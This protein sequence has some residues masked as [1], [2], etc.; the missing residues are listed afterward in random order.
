MKREKLMFGVLFGLV[1]LVG[2]GSVSAAICEATGSGVC[3]YVSPIGN[4]ANNGTSYISPFQTFQIAINLAQPGDVIYGLGGTYGSASSSTWTDSWGSNNGFMGIT[5]K[6]LS[7]SSGTSINPITIKAYPGETP[8]LDGTLVPSA[9]NAIYVDKVS[10]W[11]I[12]GFEFIYSGIYIE[13]HPSLIHNIT[14]KNNYMHHIDAGAVLSNTGMIVLYRAYFTDGGTTDI[15][16]INNTFHDLERA[17]VGWAS[18]P[19]AS[20]TG[21]LTTLS[22]CGYSGQIT[23]CY[24]TGNI[25]FINNTVYNIAK[26][27]FFKNPAAG[28]VIIKGNIFHDAESFGLLSVSSIIMTDNLVYNVGMGWNTV[29]STGGSGE[30][31]VRGQ[32]QVIM[33]NTFV[34]PDRIMSM[35]VGENHTLKNNIFFRIAQG[36]AYLSR[37]LGNPVY[38]ED[39]DPAF[40]TLQSTTSEDNCFFVPNA[41]TPFIYREYD[42]PGSE[43]YTHAEQLPVFGFDQNSIFTYETNPNNV[44]VNPASG[45]YRLKNSSLCLGMG[46]YATSAP[47][48]P[49][50]THGPGISLSYPGDVGIAGDSRVIFTENFEEA[51]LANLFSN[52]DEVL[53]GGV[54]TNFDADVSS[55]SSGSQSIRIDEAGVG[56]DRL[57]K[58]LANINPS[59]Y[60]KLYVRYYI[61]IPSGS[62]GIHHTAMLGGYNPPLN[63][64]DGRSGAIPAGNDWFGTFNGPWLSGGSP[65]WSW[66]WYTYWMG[67]NGIWGN[68]FFSSPITQPQFDTW[69][70]VEFMIKLNNPVTSSNGEMA[71]WIN[72]VLEEEWGPGYPNGTFVG[73]TFNVNPAGPPFPGFQWRNDPSLNLTFAALDYNSQTPSG[74]NNYVWFDDLVVATEYI[75]P[76]VP[77]AL[78]PTCHDVNSDGKVNIFDL[79]LVLANQGKSGPDYSHLDKDVSGVVDLGDVLNVIGDFGRS[80]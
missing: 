77:L 19:D 4:D 22:V 48:G 3:Y 49:G 71:M 5:D 2:V 34:G 42:G 47:V 45:N 75:G 10:H 11:N 59:G 46:Y 41:N 56:G 36:D 63:W 74:G 65:P 52:F 62:D 16:I 30:D 58:N 8:I 32:N 26:I 7:V 69:V 66:N 20:H 29:G 13:G 25:Y 9:G 17:G 40:S 60:E 27:F 43:T 67:M 72:G 51:T 39:P 64:F 15:F 73:D 61:K 1:L 54:G 38:S 12:E 18:I 57:F 33:R 31:R 23:P 14:I 70:P 44:F 76:I 28:P 24:G 53:N 80:C 68:N 37:K 78:P 79:A 50:G 6:A 35:N 55:D 21:V